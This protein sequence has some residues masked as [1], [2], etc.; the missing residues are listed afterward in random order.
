M[1]EVKAFFD[2]NVILYLLSSDASKAARAEEL[3]MVGGT[4]SAQVLNEF[5]AVASRKLKMSWAE[6]S[7]VVMQIREIC[8][9]EPLTV[10]TH[11]RAMAVAERYG[12]SFYDSHIVASAMIAGCNRLYSEDLQDGQVFDGLLT[13]H[14][15][16]KPDA[17]TR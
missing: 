6:I 8:P 11:E 12:L 15:P 10:E 14:N 13:V 7:E 4:I 5:A 3:M 9:V 1:S 2:T 16:F 17:K